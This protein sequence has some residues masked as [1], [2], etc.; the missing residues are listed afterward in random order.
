MMSEPSELTEEY[1]DRLQA[2]CDVVASALCVGAEALQEAAGSQNL[3]EG[4]SIEAASVWFKV[5]DAQ[6]AADELSRAIPQLIAEVRRLRGK[7]ASA[8]K[9]GILAGIIIGRSFAE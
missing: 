4:E 6:N 7:V 2:M 1:L 5:S 8:G 3:T 9:D